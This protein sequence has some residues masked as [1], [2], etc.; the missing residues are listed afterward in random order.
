MSRFIVFRGNEPERLRL[1]IHSQRSLL[2]GDISD[3]ELLSDGSTER[4]VTGT[5]THWGLGYYV[6]GEAHVQ[7][8]WDKLRAKLREVVLPEGCGTPNLDTDF[9]NTVTLLFAV[10]S[11]PAGP[12]ET[13]ARAHL[14]RARLAEL[15]AGTATGAAG[16]AAIL[17]A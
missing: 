7:Q 15:R 2:F 13:K 16:R 12:A 3:E 6:G 8:E 11:P 10:S 9:G 5:R 1:A 4:P 17:R 14:I